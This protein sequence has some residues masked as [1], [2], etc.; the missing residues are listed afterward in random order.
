MTLSPNG[1]EK[2]IS[3]FEIEVC[4]ELQ[5]RYH[6]HT[7][8]MYGSRARG[9]AAVTSDIDILG[10][11]SDG[12]EVRHCRLWQGNYLDAF[13]CP[14]TK[15]LQPDPSMVRA[16]GPCLKRIQLAVID[17]NPVSGFWEKMGYRDTGASKRHEGA[18]LVSSKRVLE[19]I[20]YA[21]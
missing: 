19:K 10:A 15:L 14:E 4:A 1:R 5:D 21:T 2:P 11:R 8:I 12:E 6:C 20:L 7:I 3:Q 9:D 13:V 17:S 18:N 16:R